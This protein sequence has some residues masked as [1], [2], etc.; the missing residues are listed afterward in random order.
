MIISR[1]YQVQQ[2]FGLQRKN[3]SQLAIQ[4]RLPTSEYKY[5]F[6]VAAQPEGYF[7]SCQLLAF[8]IQY[9]QQ[10]YYFHINE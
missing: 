2:G 6:T 7:L 10:C 8:G 4:Q 3:K 5:R 1:K 9:S